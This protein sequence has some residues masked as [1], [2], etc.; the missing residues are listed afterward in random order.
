MSKREGKLTSISAAAVGP[1]HEVWPFV[2]QSIKDQAAS[3][4]GKVVSYEGFQVASMTD[5]ED[6]DGP[7]MV[8]H[9]HI[10]KMVEQ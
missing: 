1:G 4:G 8:L 10:W 7:P 6:P 3:M 5:P 2:E 9:R